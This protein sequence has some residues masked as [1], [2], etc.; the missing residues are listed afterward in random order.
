[1]MKKI[2]NSWQRVKRESENSSVLCLVMDVGSVEA[3]NL[4]SSRFVS[5]KCGGYRNPTDPMDPR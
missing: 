4:S 3:R 5:L 2:E 1:V